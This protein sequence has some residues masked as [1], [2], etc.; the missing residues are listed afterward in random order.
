[1]V[2]RPRNP[3]IERIDVHD[4][5][6]AMTIAE[7]GS[8][9]RSAISLNTSQPTLTRRIRKLEVALGQ[10]LLRRTLTGVSLTD[11]GRKI[12][13]HALTIET[14]LSSIINVAENSRTQ[15]IRLGASL[16]PATLLVPHLIEATCS[17]HLDIRIVATEGHY[18]SLSSELR[19]GRLDVVFACPNVKAKACGAGFTALFWTRL[20]IVASPTH[21]LACKRDVSL[22]DLRSAKWVLLGGDPS[23]QSRVE[24]EL[25]RNNLQIPSNALKMPSPLAVW[26]F[27]R[28][29]DALAIVPT[30]I[31]QNEISNGDCVVIRG[32]WR[33]TPLAC[34]AFVNESAKATH[35]LSAVIEVAKRVVRDLGLPIKG[36]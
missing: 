19:Q 31:L 5:F 20:G 15:Q 36:L 21:P 27:V 30:E 35:E 13:E 28:R 14:A 2:D 23:F 26:Q 18:E 7:N 16:T 32:S 34:G 22:E 1:M 3:K 9:S 6:T 25:G 4:L 11:F 24:Y 29:G 33:F 8:I 17:T 12:R 10:D